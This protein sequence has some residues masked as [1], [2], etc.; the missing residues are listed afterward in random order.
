MYSHLCLHERI[1]RPR[2][3]YPFGGNGK[4]DSINQDNIEVWVLKKH[5]ILSDD[6]ILLHF[7]KIK[8]EWVFA[9]KNI[10][11]SEPIQISTGTGT[12]YE[13]R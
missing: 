3:P 5:N 9:T 6:F 13:V 7:N 1:Q 4:K 8:M 12:P 10:I 11:W 2:K